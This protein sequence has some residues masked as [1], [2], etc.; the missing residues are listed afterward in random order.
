MLLAVVHDFIANLLH[1]VNR[2]NFP[3]HSEKRKFQAL[4]QGD[5]GGR[6]RVDVFSDVHNQ[7]GSVSV[8][9]FRYGSTK[10]FRY[11]FLALVFRVLGM[12]ENVQAGCHGKLASANKFNGVGVFGVAHPA[13][14]LVEAVFARDKLEPEHIDCVIVDVLNA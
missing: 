5:Y 14:I 6:N 3:R 8:G 11:V 7:A 2:V 9:Q 12:P 4:A 13:H 1:Q 10:E